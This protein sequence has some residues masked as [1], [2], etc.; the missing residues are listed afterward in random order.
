[1]NL[2][3]GGAAAL[4]GEIFAPSYLA[5]RIWV[6]ATTYAPDGTMTRDET[7]ADCLAQVDAATERMVQTE[8]YTTSDRALYVLAASYDGVLDTDCEIAVDEG[9][10]AGTRW[11]VAAPIDRDPAAAYWL[12]R[13]VL[14]EPDPDFQNREPAQNVSWAQ[15][16]W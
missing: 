8:G 1:M 5:A 11:K 12:C 13:G 9:P 14:Q 6:G 2:L 4:F 10:Y 7:T 3:G 16:D 15:E